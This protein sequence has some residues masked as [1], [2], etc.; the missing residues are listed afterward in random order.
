MPG[1]IIV[2]KENK[3]D[4]SP[5]VRKKRT[6]GCLCVTCFIEKHG[7]QREKCTRCKVNLPNRKGGLCL[8][9]SKLPA[10]GVTLTE[11]T[12]E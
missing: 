2:F 6:K 10:E 3:I 7:D 8:K 11:S 5:G 9:C 4:V 12:T 1:V